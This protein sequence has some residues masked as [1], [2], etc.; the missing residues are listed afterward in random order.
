MKCN[1]VQ[2]ML[3]DYVVNKLSNGQLNA[4]ESHVRGC[5]H[6][7]QAAKELQEVLVGLREVQVSEPSETYFTTILPRIHKR[8]EALQSGFRIPDYFLRLVM[9]VAMVLVTLTVIGNYHKVVSLP[10]PTVTANSTIETTSDDLTYILGQQEVAAN[11]KISSQDQDEIS[12]LL[13]SDSSTFPLT[14]DDATTV[15]TSLD[16]NDFHE[17]Y[18]ILQKQAEK[19]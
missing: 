6:C 7:Q 1:Y 15:A 12:E 16:Q 17:F 5:P 8:I 3:P 4:I 18:S 14:E 13:I 10:T 2:P 11:D 9:P 19:Y